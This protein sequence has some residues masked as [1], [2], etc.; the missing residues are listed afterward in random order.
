MENLIM[1]PLNSLENSN[2]NKSDKNEDE[3][4]SEEDL[5]DNLSYVDPR[6]NT[7]GIRFITSSQGMRGLIDSF[8]E[9]IFDY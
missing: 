7:L 5:Y 9:L 8:I 2:S 3:N 1:K 6:N 4:N